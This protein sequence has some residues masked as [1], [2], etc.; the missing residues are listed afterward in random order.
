ML[1]TPNLTL[2]LLTRRIWWAPNSTNKWQLGF[3][4]AFKGLIYLSEF[5]FTTQQMSDSLILFTSLCSNVAKWNNNCYLLLCQVS[6]L[7][8]HF[9]LHCIMCMKPYT[10]LWLISF[11]I[12]LRFKNYV[13]SCSK[14]RSM[15]NGVQTW[16]QCNRILIPYSADFCYTAQ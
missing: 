11:F 15:Q 14:S 1:D 4:S 7:Y 5:I 8:F 12:D 3:N 10:I 9:F 16:P 13:K 6:E 2:I